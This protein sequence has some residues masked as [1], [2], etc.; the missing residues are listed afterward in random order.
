[1]TR[2]SHSFYT[3]DS[4]FRANKWNILPGARFEIDKIQEITSKNNIK[5]SSVY[6]KLASE[7]YFKSLGRSTERM[8]SPGIIHISTHG[9]FFPD[10]IT[11]N[12]IKKAPLKTN[13][14]L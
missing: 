12:K 11:S 14:Y 10:P 1:M 3:V 6:G 2:G 7:E 8:V 9:F 5:T 4:T 13:L